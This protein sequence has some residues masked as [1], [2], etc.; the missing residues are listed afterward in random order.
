MEFK[1]SE[2]NKGLNRWKKVIKN[3]P[4]LRYLGSP[5]LRKKC[6]TVKEFNS[7]TKKDIAKLKKIF[8]KY[9]EMTG[10]GRGMSAPQIGILKNIVVIFSNDVLKT[11]VNPKITTSSEEMTIAEEL[12]MSMGNLSAFVV[13]PKLITVEYQNE[14]GKSIK[15]KANKEESRIIQHEMDH[16]DGVLNIDKTIKNGLRFVYNIKQFEG[17]KEWNGEE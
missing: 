12:C 2:L 11:L 13:R 16:L 14:T 3:I 7:E 10:V 6:A 15:L 9:R 1:S 5:D 17:I 4:E 8:L